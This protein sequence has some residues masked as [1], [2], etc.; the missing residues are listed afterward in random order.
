MKCSPQGIKSRCSRCHA[1][2]AQPEQPSLSVRPCRTHRKTFPY[3]NDSAWQKC[4]LTGCPGGNPS[5]IVGTESRLI[6]IIEN[7]RLDMQ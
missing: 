5:S 3:C 7:Q 2:S 1:F 4:L 6:L